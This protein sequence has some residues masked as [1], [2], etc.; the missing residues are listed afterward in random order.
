M[1]FQALNTNTYQRIQNNNINNN[2]RP[3]RRDHSVELG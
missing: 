3:N 2:R 1:S